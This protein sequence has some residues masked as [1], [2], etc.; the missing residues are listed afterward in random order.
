MN[1]P[2]HTPA[3]IALAA[4]K[5]AGLKPKTL[6]MYRI[7]WKSWQTWCDANGIDPLGAT[8][9]D[10]TAFQADHKYNTRTRAEHASALFHPYR[11][12]GKPSPAHRPT[13]QNHG[14]KSNSDPILKRFESWCKA[15]G[16]TSLPAQL[17]DVV[18]FLTELAKTHPKSYLKH[19]VTAIGRMHTMAG[20]APPSRE[21]EVT[22]AL[23]HLK[24]TPKQ[25]VTDTYHAERRNR[26]IAQWTDWH[27]E[28]GFEPAAATAA[29]T[30][31]H[32]LQF[33]KQLATTSSA[34]TLKTCR[35]EIAHMYPDRSITYNSQTDALIEATP[36]AGTRRAEH[37]ALRKQADAEIAL[38]LQ[39]EADLMEDQGSHLPIEKRKRIARAMAHADI[40][41]QTLLS[42]V[43]Y[44]WLPFKE[45]CK[46]NGTSPETATPGDV[47]AFLC[48]IADEAGPTYASA[49]LDGLNHVF[50]RIRPSDNPANVASVRKTVKGLK[51]ERP[52]PPQQ[53]TAIGTEDLAILIKTAHNERPRE[54][55]DRNRLR[56]AV[57]IAL[58]CT[59]YDSA[60]RAEEA[61]EAEWDDLH[62]APD[63]R[64]GSVLTIRSSKTDQLHEGA[65][66]YLT[67]FTTDAINHMKDVRQELGIADKEDDRIF[68]LNAQSIYR[69]IRAACKFAKL[70]GRY[71]AHSLRVGSAQDLLTEN[72]SDAQIMH[73]HRWKSETSLNH[74]TKA[75]KAEKNAVAQREQRRKQDGHTR[76]PKHNNYGIKVPHNKAR[77]GQ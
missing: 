11:H 53:A 10:Y 45:W 55:E 23:K 49:T 62:N 2:T 46:T 35:Y 63:G 67:K 12:V 30:A 69:H 38:I 41:D 57:D 42:Y 44:A 21:P 48:E 13:S 75:T 20:Y 76:K 60:I 74:Y 29:A 1:N 59:M 71:T 39:T 3:D 50:K 31:E 28:Q 15:N 7:R 68:R 14:S 32:F 25:L 27:R 66:Q 4:W 17:Q 56:A 51:R 19:A 8:H 64:G 65:V 22:S 9:D 40:T 70:Q 5:A 54:L 36:P 18:S 73:H 47:S 6:S 34:D 52:S 43:R 61:A 16:T 33:L 58:I 26:R 37:S 77:L 72:F 24:G